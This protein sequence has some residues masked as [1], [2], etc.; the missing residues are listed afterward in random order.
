MSTYHI[1]KIFQPFGKTVAI[2]RKYNFC[3]ITIWTYR[4]NVLKQ[5]AEMA[6][7]DGHWLTVGWLGD[8]RGVCD[9]AHAAEP[10]RPPMPAADEWPAPVVGQPILDR[11]N[12][13][14]L[15]LIFESA[16]LSL[17]DLKSLAN[18]CTR[19]ERIAKLVFGSKY[20]DLANNF[21]VPK[22]DLW[23]THELVRTFGDTITAVNLAQV[24]DARTDI[25]LRMIL[26]H[27]PNVVQLEC[28]VHEPHTMLAMRA[29]VPKLRRLKIRMRE[30]NDFPR[31]FDAS[32]AHCHLQQLRA[33]H[34]ILPA[35]PLARL[36]EL[37]AT[38]DDTRKQPS[39]DAF[40]ALNGQLAKVTLSNYDFDTGIGCIVQ[41]LPHLRELGLD[42]VTFGEHTPGDASAVAQLTQL[43]T[44]RIR[45]RDD[46]ATAVLILQ[47][48]HGGR[49]QLECFTLDG[50]GGDARLIDALCGL[51]SIRRLKIDRLDEAHLMRLAHELT[52]LE[53]VGV[54]CDRLP[55]HSIRDALRV[56]RRLT[57]ATFKVRS[58]I[59]SAGWPKEAIIRDID[60]IK[61]QRCMELNVVLRRRARSAHEAR[62]R[63]H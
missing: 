17:W 51:K 47:A 10:S 18:V 21:V 31:L 12:D 14:C 34:A 2:K 35:L 5:R 24:A 44:L 8:R 54:E 62:A 19:F 11:L 7:A 52:H 3:D 42:R 43:K 32:A 49:A 16:R 26:E 61:R 6:V 40:F 25:E 38:A 36:V 41:H 30:P 53:C 23:Q 37:H 20:R 55:F 46:S 60:D 39:I 33:T 1:F 27:C 45:V 4:W 56:A 9:L 29:R 50:F 59:F 13:D 28:V 48:L 63:V 15:R 57:K 22:D 58:P